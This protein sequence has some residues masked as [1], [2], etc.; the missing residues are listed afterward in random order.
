MNR[1]RSLSSHYKEC[2]CL[3]LLI[4][5]LI[6]LSSPSLPPSL[7]AVV[8]VEGLCLQP[9]CRLRDGAH[10]EGEVVLCGL[11]HRAGA[12]AG[13]GDHRT[14]GII[15]GGYSHVYIF[16]IKHKS[17]SI[18]VDLIGRYFNK[19]VL[20]HR[21]HQYTG[22]WYSPYINPWRQSL[23]YRFLYLFVR[24]DSHSCWTA[25]ELTM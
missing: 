4:L 2:C 23:G 10:D 5:V 7:D 3:T 20:D 11:Q 8:V 24:V 18:H 12:E 21:G 6:P 22:C 16:K 17:A 1:L 15:H 25:A 14:G 13:A 9:L 19:N